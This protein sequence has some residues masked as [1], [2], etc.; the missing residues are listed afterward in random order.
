[1]SHTLGC[2]S[3]SHFCVNDYIAKTNKKIACDFFSC[4]YGVRLQVIQS[5]LFEITV[6]V[7]THKVPLNTSLMSRDK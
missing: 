6:I 4:L 1:M 5:F 7:F 2:S 3:H